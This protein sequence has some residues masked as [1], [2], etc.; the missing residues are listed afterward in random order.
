M[1]E[2]FSANILS[3]VLV[4]GTVV[5]IHELGH[6]FVAKLLKIRVEAFA[7]GFGPRLFGFR[8]AE[9]DYR[10]CAIPL[11]G[12]VKMT[13][14]NPSEGL[15]GGVEEFLSRPKWQRFLVA[16]MGPVMNVLLAIIL[17]TAVFYHKF[18]TPAWL[19]EPV[20]VGI[21]ESNSPAEKAGIQAGDRIVAIGNQRNLTW[22]E[23]SLEVATSAN[24]PLELEISR[25]DQIIRK[26]VIPESQGKHH[27]GYLGVFPYSPSLSVVKNI[28]GGKPA[29]EAGMRP[30]DKIIKVGDVDLERAGKDLAD[31][32]NLYKDET[33]PIV[34]W[35]N[36]QQLELKVKPYLDK[37]SKRRMIGIE[38]DQTQKMIV[39]NLT[40]KEAF[41]ESVKQNIK[42][43]GLIF[44]ILQKLFKHE[45]SIRM[46]SGPIGIAQQSGIAARSGFTDLVFLMAA[47]SLNLGIMNLLPIPVLD[48]GIIAII[49]V[50]TLIRR[51]LSLRLRERIT[52]VGFVVLILLA[53]IITYN[54][55][56][57]VLPASLEKY[58]P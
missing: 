17:L 22:E 46:M 3:V 58:F 23:F 35:R 34:V 33:V 43:T 50:E 51:D 56:I 38:R 19:S 41:Q 1:L 36:G 25:K 55:I 12:Y 9:T 2:F 47:I 57:K 10:V 39:R 16:V 28:V 45:V 8:K 49:V 21:I 7:V 29:A 42:F 37:A 13:G 30:G 48:G 26:T 40:V 24:R 5:I 18:E 20:V 14:E 11:G 52:Q 4:F 31:V 32:L 44:D 53:V 15:T 6:F 27:G 54:D